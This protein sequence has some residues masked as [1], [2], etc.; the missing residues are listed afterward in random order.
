[1]NPNMFLVQLFGAHLQ[2]WMLQLGRFF[3]QRFTATDGAFKVSAILSIGF[4]AIGY[5]I[6]WGSWNMD[7]Q[8]GVAFGV[9]LMTI[10]GLLGSVFLLITMAHLAVIGG[11]AGAL[12]VG[13]DQAS[14]PF[15][16]SSLN[17][18]ATLSQENIVAFLRT[19]SAIFATLVL[20]GLYVSF[21]PVY[22]SMAGFLAVLL[23]VFFLMFA[24]FGFASTQV[25]LP[26][27]QRLAMFAAVAAIIVHTLQFVCLA[28]GTTLASIFNPFGVKYGS[29][30]GQGRDLAPEVSSWA[31]KLAQQ[32]GV[33]ETIIYA[34]FTLVWII[35]L[36][37]FV[38]IVIP[39]LLRRLGII[40]STNSGRATDAGGG[41]T[42]GSGL[43]TLAMIAVF[44]VVAWLALQ[45]VFSGLVALSSA[46][47]P[48]SGSGVSQQQTRDKTDQPKLAERWE[49]FGIV[50][51]DPASTQY[52]DTGL[53]VKTG[54]VISYE[55]ANWQGQFL[56]KA[57]DGDRE[58]AVSNRQQL[59][60]IT[61]GTLKVKP[62]RIDSTSG[63]DKSLKIVIR[64]RL[65]G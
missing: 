41:S 34:G 21:V 45:L 35:G 42:S 8:G 30:D 25:W 5:L 63:S 39:W 4:S 46:G 36:L 64:K 60:I 62:F 22:T 17:F 24:A 54:D 1:M 40:E 57:F 50:E 28:G 44:A 48:S 51:L 56:H 38:G 53:K 13:V 15:P 7:F 61:G 9:L 11:A 43:K 47:A 37:I 33:S 6:A 16:G 58:I 52:Q 29:A 23:C 3:S 49:Q 19:M 27:L 31:S 12:A 10:G 14:R 18:S 55:F 65:E 20:M 59:T 2:G 26:R 32:S